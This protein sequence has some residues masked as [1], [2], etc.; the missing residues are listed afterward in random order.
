MKK[1]DEER[2]MP[3]S[4]KEKVRA[5]LQ[6]ENMTKCIPLKRNAHTPQP[7]GFL[8]RAKYIPA[9][10]KLKSISPQPSTSGVHSPVLSNLSLSSPQLSTFSVRPSTNVDIRYVNLYKQS[11]ILM[12]EEMKLKVKLSRQ[13]E[14][15]ES[16]LLQKS[17]LEQQMRSIGVALKSIN[18]E[19]EKNVVGVI[20]KERERKVVSDQ[21]PM[22]VIK[23][24]SC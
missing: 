15:K 5:D 21:I 14:E 10:T 20:L 4:S 24:M 16:L 6:K 7:S 19:I 17:K 3:N 13:Q 22:H 18:G 8:K 9:V 1:K 11:K 2:L 12:L 23:Q